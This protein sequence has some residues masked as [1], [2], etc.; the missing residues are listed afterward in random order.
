MEEHIKKALDTMLKKF[1]DINME[2]EVARAKIIEGIEA[3]LKDHNQNT[4]EKI[5]KKVE[6]LLED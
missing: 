1:R 6:T 4:K 5:F 3:T 2:S